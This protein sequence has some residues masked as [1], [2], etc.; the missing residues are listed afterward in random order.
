MR[1]IEEAKDRFNATMY[2]G[3]NAL[4]RRQTLEEIGGF[5]TGVIT[6]DMATG[7]LI[8]ANGWETVFVNKVLAVG[9]VPETYRNLLK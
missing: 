9:L 3:S 2:I 7:M 8:Q 4:F 1:L 6:E 5:A